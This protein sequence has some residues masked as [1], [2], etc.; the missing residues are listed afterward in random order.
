[1]FLLNVKLPYRFTKDTMGGLI[2]KVITKDFFLKI[3][4]SHLTFVA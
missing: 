3:K 4:K 2:D 1:M